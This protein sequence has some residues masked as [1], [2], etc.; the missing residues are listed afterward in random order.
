MCIICSTPVGCSSGGKAMVLEHVVVRDLD[1]RRDVLLGED[2]DAHLPCQN[3][4][5][6][7]KQ[8]GLPAPTAAVLRQGRTQCARPPR[9]ASVWVDLCQHPASFDSQ[10]SSCRSVAQRREEYNAADRS[11]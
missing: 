5:Q 9:E 10:L 6:K 3:T 8:G 4:T 2:P 11:T 1:A 7:S